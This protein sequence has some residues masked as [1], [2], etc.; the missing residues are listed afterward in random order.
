[1]AYDNDLDG[2][3]SCIENGDKV[4]VEQSDVLFNYFISILIKFLIN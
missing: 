3:K 2:V 4:N 1:M